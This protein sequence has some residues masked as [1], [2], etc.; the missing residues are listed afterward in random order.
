MVC[1]EGLNGS[2]KALQFNFKELLLPN[3]ANAHEPAQDLPMIDVDLS[4]AEPKVQLSTRVE[5]PLSLNL[6]GALEQL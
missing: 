6:R 2:L 5:D 4:G 3:A 1:P